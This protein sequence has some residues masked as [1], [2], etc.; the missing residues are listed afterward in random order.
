MR[1]SALRTHCSAKAAGTKVCAGSG[2][3][4]ELQPRSLEYLTLVAEAEVEREH[5]AEA[6]ECYR[7]IINRDPDHVTAHNALGLLLQEE[8]QLELAVEYLQT[9]LR[10]AARPG[11]CSRHHG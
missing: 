4:S 7:E 2:A 5:F 10:L 6:I 8:G 1:V 11:C 3:R 9:A